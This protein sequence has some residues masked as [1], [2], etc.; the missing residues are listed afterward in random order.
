MTIWDTT[1]SPFGNVGS[2]NL[3]LPA[4]WVFGGSTGGMTSLDEDLRGVDVGYD[5]DRYGVDG[6]YFWGPNV[7]LAL[8]YKRDERNGF[9]SQFATI[10]STSTQLLTPLDDATDRVDAAVRYQAEHWFAELTYSGSFYNTK[11][12]SLKWTNPFGLV[13]ARH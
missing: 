7:V 5:R 12:A 9:R 11:A 8:D 6:K 3:T 10:G 4:N 2:R 1:Q 13:A